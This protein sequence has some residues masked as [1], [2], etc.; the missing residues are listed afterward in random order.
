MS[1]KMIARTEGI[2]HIKL[3]IVKEFVAGDEK[4]FVAINDPDVYSGT[5]R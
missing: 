3:L 4:P 2:V 1:F 5:C